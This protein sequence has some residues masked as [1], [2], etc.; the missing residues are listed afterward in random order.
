MK[1]VMRRSD[2]SRKEIKFDISH[3]KEL[4]ELRELKR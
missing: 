1:Q 2:Q 3:I 4:E